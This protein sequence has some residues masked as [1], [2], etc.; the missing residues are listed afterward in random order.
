MDSKAKIGLLIG[1]VILFFIVFVL[2]GLPGIG[3]ARESDKLL[4]FVDSEPLG[5]IPEMPPEAFPPTRVPEQPPKDTPP[6]KDQQRFRVQLLATTLPDE[7]DNSVELVKQAWP[8]IHVVRKGD[9]LTDIAKRYYGPKEGNRRANIKRI[10][11]GNQKSL[12]SPN[13]IYPGQKLIIPSL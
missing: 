8:K 5:I 9:N 12:K 3:D 6:P 10:F 7:I 13:K 2:N 1:L 11:E 4:K